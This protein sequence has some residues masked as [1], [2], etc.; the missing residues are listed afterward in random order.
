MHHDVD[1]SEL[2][3]FKNKALDRNEWGQFE[4]VL[5]WSK[6]Y[7]IKVEIYS[8]S[9]NM[10]TIDGDEFLTHKEVIILLYCN[11]RKWGDAENHYDLMYPIP[12]HI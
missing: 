2:I 4:H 5:I 11:E 6:I 1:Q 10:H 12:Q 9:M 7:Q 3:D 8:Y